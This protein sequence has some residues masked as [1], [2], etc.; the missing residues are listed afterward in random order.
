MKE[1][2][3]EFEKDPPTCK[4][5]HCGSKTVLR[6]NR[7]NNRLFIGCSNFPKCRQTMKFEKWV[8]D[9]IGEY[10][11]DPYAYELSFRSIMSRGKLGCEKD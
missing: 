10:Y 1:Y 11:E 4:A 7:E 5:D 3:Q 2:V 8:A 9:Y 6:K